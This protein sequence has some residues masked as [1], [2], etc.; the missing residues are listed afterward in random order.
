MHALHGLI[1]NKQKAGDDG[2]N[3]PTPKAYLKYGVKYVTSYID[4]EDSILVL[5]ETQLSGLDL[6]RKGKIMVWWLSVENY[7]FSRHRQI[8]AVNNNIDTYNFKG[9]S[10]VIHFAQS[11][12]AK[13]FVQEIL[14]I[15][16][17]YDLKDYINEEI[18]D[19]AGLYSMAYE[20]KN[21]CLYNPK[22]GYENLR[23]VIEACRTDL[24]WIPLEG[25]KPVEVAEL[26]CQ[27]KVYVDFGSHPGKDRIPREAAICGCCVLTNQEGSA[28]WQ[29][30]VR[31][32]DKYK[33]E[34]TGDIEAVLERIYDLMDHYEERREEYSNYRSAIEEE[35]D[36]FKRD[37]QAALL[38]LEDFL[39][40][41]HTKRHLSPDDALNSDASLASLNAAA[42]QLNRIILAARKD[43]LRNDYS[44]VIN[45]LLNVDY[46]IRVMKETIYMEINVLSLS[47][48]EK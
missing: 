19:F 48:S 42:D 37:A 1:V 16:E 32:P 45:K 15:R 12:Y 40:Q 5:A 36:E 30:D 6:C 26:M 23:P 9:R 33:I 22:K 31:I 24:E 28:R 14:G 10:N 34:N 47:D 43:G 20:R 4:A 38:K 29:E 13:N 39:G 44:G 8:I 41:A 3:C 46:L 21:V 11:Y 2:I 7:L 18:M 35:R 17:C 25:Y 27:S